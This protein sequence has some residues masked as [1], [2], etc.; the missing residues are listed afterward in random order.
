MKPW[1]RSAMAFEPLGPVVDGVHRRDDGEEHLR[2]ADVARRLLA[3]DVLLAR[4]E[5]HPQRGVAVGVDGD[6]DDAAGDLP[7]EVVG[8]GEERGV[9]AAVAERHAEALRVADGHVRAELA[10]RRRAASARGG[11][12]RRRRTRRRRARRRR[13]RRSPRPR[14]PSSGTARAPRTRRRRTRTRPG[15]RR[16]P[17]PRSARRGLRRRRSSAGGSVSATK[18][19]VF[20]PRACPKN[21][22]IASAAAVPSSRSEAFAIGSPV[23][24]ATTVWK[25]SS[26]SSRPCAISA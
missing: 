12:W 24:S 15:R 2:R 13:R 1:T 17:R 7:L 25:L 3:A 18:N 4:L 14:R 22:L 9:G 8:G 16:R 6:A 26:A 5:R 11:R 20:F 19:C 21:M 10:G 23:R